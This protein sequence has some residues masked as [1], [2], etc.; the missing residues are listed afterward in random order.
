MLFDDWE[1]SHTGW[2]GACGVY[3]ICSDGE[4]G[5]II[6]NYVGSSKDIGNRLARK[7][8]HYLRL[9][10]EGVEVY[11]RFKECKDYKKFEIEMIKL[12]KPKLNKAHNYLYD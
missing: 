4:D 2:N 1:I 11:I 12:L 3:C 9:W 10:R 8:H 7:E 6:V 5:E